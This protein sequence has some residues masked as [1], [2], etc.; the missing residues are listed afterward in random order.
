[1]ATEAKKFKTTNPAF[2]FV[3]YKDDE[4]PQAVGGVTSAGV[5]VWSLV[6]IAI[7]CITGAFAWTQTYGY[8]HVEGIDI[9]SLPAQAWTWAILGLVGGTVLA[10]VTIFIPRICPFTA[11]FYSAFEGLTLGTISAAFE[12]AYPGIILNTVIS[13]VGV[14]GVVAVLYGTGVIKVNKTFMTVLLSCMI[15]ILLTYIADIVLSIFAGYRMPMLHEQGNWW[16]IGFSVLVIIV[17]G[18]NFAWDFENVK[19]AQE[20]QAPKYYESYLAFGFMLTLVWLYLEVLRLWA[21][22]SGRKD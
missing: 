9:T 7:M 5:M 14:F 17:A 4:L 19:L 2:R 16:A 18:L 6:Y 22:M 20:S 3:T 8:S 11:P 21:L 13:T 12:H 1:M 10:F 15:A